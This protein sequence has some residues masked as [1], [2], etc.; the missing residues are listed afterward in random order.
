[1]VSLFVHGEERGEAKRQPSSSKHREKG[2]QAASRKR[3]VRVWGE[4]A[5]DGNIQQLLRNILD[6]I[7]FWL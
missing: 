2:N 1:M 4:K 5:K 6:S 7:C 3:V